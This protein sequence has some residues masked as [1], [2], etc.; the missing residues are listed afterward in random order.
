MS[1][2]AFANILSAVNKMKEGSSYSSDKD[3]YWSCETDKAGN[4]QAVIRFLP[5]KDGESLPFVRRYSHGFKV[6]SKWFIDSCR[7][8]LGESCPVCESNGELWNSGNKEDQEIARKRK[9]KLSFIT[10][11]LVVSDP[12]NP[13]NEGKVFLFKFG[14]K[15]FDKIVD[16]MQPEFDDEDPINPFDPEEGCDFKLK[17]RQVEGYANFD[18]SEFSSTSDRSK[19][20]SKILEDIEDL[21]ELV[22]PDK[23]TSYAD[24]QKRLNGVLGI[25]GKAKKEESDEDEVDEDDLAFL[26]KAAAKSKKD[27]VIEEDVPFDVDVKKE[28]PKKKP[29][30]PVTDD[31]DDFDSDFFKSLAEDD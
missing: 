19:E 17:I 22:S 3:K 16:K 30:P 10:N 1:K 31:E 28:E 29:K 20:I 2:N 13:D 25:G 6:G 18:K 5:S 15:I 21:Q 23:F 14:K 8:T 27:E 9:R 4:G 26:K 7:T 24:Q 11:I 12:K